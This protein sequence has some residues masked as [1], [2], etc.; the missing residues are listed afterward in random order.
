[1]LRTLLFL[2]VSSVAVSSVEAAVQ[3]KKITYKAGSTESIGFLAWDD[4]IEGAR[5][6]V[7]VVHEWWGLDG[8]AKRRAEQL[9]KLGYIAF[10]ADMYGGGKLV[11][12]PNDARTMAG[13]VRSSIDEWRKRALA[14]FDV[15]KAQPQCDSSK[16]AAIGYCFGGSTV[17]QL[18]YAGTD[19]KAVVSFHGALVPPKPEEVKAIKAAV[20]IC[21]G[22]DDPF[23]NADAV[24]AFK[25]AFDQ[26]GGKYT[27]KSYEGARHS[28]TVPEADEASK[29]FNLDG[30]KYN[31]EADEKSW[32]EMQALFKEKLGK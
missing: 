7:L 14:A 1:M 28:F 23:I 5:P 26:N 32:A 13:Q 6:G 29:K 15:L 19:L 9:A 24:K 21:H 22:A 12:H 27:F 8:Y 25:T 30:M 18:A 2:V 31:K 4:A 10:A 3:T 20:L 11:D 16:L 17:Q